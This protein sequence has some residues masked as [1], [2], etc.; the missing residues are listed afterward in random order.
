MITKRQ[1]ELLDFIT[2]FTKENGFCPSYDEMRV[3]L[4]LVS[5]SSVHKLINSLEERG[6]I[7]RLPNRARAIEIINA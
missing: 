7:R 2:A 1:K 6:K 4:K 5:R 3:S